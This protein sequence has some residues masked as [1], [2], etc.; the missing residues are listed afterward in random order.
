M[1]AAELIEQIKALPPGEQ[2]IV[3]KFLLNGDGESSDS[4]GRYASDQEFQDAAGRVFEKHQE[5]LR[6]LAL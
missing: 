2:E 4:H 5:V 6:K 3:R 1:S